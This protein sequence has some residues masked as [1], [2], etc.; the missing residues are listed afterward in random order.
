MHEEEEPEV[1]VFVLRYDDEL[2]YLKNEGVV[3]TGMLPSGFK[4]R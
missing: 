2:A 1:L 4:V 3:R